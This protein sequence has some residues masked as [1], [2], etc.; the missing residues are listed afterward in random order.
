MHFTK[1]MGG[2]LSSA[3]AHVHTTFLYLRNGLAD[4]VQ[5]WCVGLGSLTT[6]FLKVMGGVHLHVRTCAPLFCISV[7]AGRIVLKFDGWL[8]VRDPV[9]M[10]FMRFWLGTS[11]RAHVHT[12]S[13]YLKNRLTD[14]AKIWRLTW[15]QI[16]MRFAKVEAG[17]IAHTHVRLQFCCLG[18]RW[19]LFLKPHQKQVYLFRARSFI[20]KHDVLLVLDILDWVHL[21]YSISQ[22]GFWNFVL[23]CSQSIRRHVFDGIW[24]LR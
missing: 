5:I 16:V 2:V 17:V 22:N 13:P 15:D 10:R 18:N 20:A 8:L 23:N 12:P 14:C 7:I 1:D 21:W 11:A 19:A 24:T 4:C 9:D 6:C 3:R